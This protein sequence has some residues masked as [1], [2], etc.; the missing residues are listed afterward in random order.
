MLPILFQTLQQGKIDSGCATG[1]HEES[2]V[3]VCDGE[4][5]MHAS[6]QKPDWSVPATQ[7]ALIASVLASVRTTNGRQQLPD[8]SMPAIAP[9]F[10]KNGSV[11]TPQLRGLIVFLP[12]WIV[13]TTDVMGEYAHAFACRWK[14]HTGVEM[15]VIKNDGGHQPKPGHPIH[16]GVPRFRRMIKGATGVLPAQEATMALIRPMR[17]AAAASKSPGNTERSAVLAL[18]AYQ[19]FS[20]ADALVSRLSDADVLMLSA[21]P[22]LSDQENMRARLSR[23]GIEQSLPNTPAPRRPLAM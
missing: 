22:G 2:W 9:L 4:E 23:M 14:Q 12:P 16:D 3:F 17:E 15:Q 21:L 5:L 10:L 11:A 18:H 1:M 19:E 13:S 7:D 6:A 20:Q 8:D